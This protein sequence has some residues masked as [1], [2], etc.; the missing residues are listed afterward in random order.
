[1]IPSVRGFFG[2]I[3]LTEAAVTALRDRGCEPIWRQRAPPNDGGRAP[4]RAV[5]AA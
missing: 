1:M 2:D 5:W 3:R 4:G